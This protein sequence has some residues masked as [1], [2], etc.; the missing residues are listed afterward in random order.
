MGI[1]FLIVFGD[2]VYVTWLDENMFLNLVVVVV[3]VGMIGG[4]QIAVD[5]MGMMVS[6]IVDKAKGKILV[7]PI[8]L[9]I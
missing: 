9:V 7:Q 6:F 8:P 1:V 4:R 3:V 5:I 2:I